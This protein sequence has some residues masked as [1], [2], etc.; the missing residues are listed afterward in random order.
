[1]VL[2][3]EVRGTGPVLLMIPGG[4]GEAAGYL[5]VAGELAARFTVVS[6]DRRG[7]GH[8][9][10]ADVVDDG[11]RFATDVADALGLLDRF[12]DAPGYVF[13][14]SSG[15]IIGLDL[16]ARYPQR[17]AGLVAHEP[18][19][20][21][22]LPDADVY[23]RL[24]DGVF[25]IY[26]REGTEAAMRAFAAGVGLD[27]PE[28]PPGRTL[29][30]EAVAML[31]RVRDDQAYFLE[32]ELRQYSALLPAE[33]ALREWSSRLVLGVGRDSAGTLPYR[34]AG[35]LAERLGTKTVEFPGD[36]LGYISQPAEFA[37]RLVEVL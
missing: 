3:H 17:I 13:G 22:L 6:Y 31:A 36:H 11:Q 9:R 25:D 20:V 35:V 24:F 15:A 21:R 16:L 27:M 14:S 7:Y 23:L 2:Y 30:P 10:S 8:S 18:P 28:P 29:R 33:D 26:R 19:M 32:H 34:P 37:A 4:A 1:M 5:R 12:S